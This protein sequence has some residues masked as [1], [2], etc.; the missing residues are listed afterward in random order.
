MAPHGDRW[1]V[2]MS[3]PHLSQEKPHLSNLQARK[4]RF[5]SMCKAESLNQM[6]QGF[7]WTFLSPSTQGSDEPNQ[8]NTTEQGCWS[9][10]S[11]LVMA[12]RCPRLYTL[13]EL[14]LEGSVGAPGA[15]GWWDMLGAASLMLEKFI[16]LT[17]RHVPQ[18]LFLSPNSQSSRLQS[19]SESALLP[20]RVG[21]TFGITWR[22][23]SSP[24]A[25]STHF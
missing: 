15:L 12:E 23:L 20:Q 7:L 5:S 14:T 11:I 24:T 25:I 2:R 6:C 21:H 4:L 17:G 1:Q 3:K 8:Y 19:C 10:D 13:C 16:S 18:S 9:K 22:Q